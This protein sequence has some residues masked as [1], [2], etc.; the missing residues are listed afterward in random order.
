MNHTC[1]RCGYATRWR[2]MMMLHV[3]NKYDVVLHN[4]EYYSHKHT[5]DDDVINGEDGAAKQA[6]DLV[7]QIT[8]LKKSERCWIDNAKA[9]QVGYNEL[10]KRLHEERTRLDFI[11]SATAFLVQHEGG[12]QVWTA[13]E[14]EIFYVLHDVTLF[15]ATEREAIDEAIARPMKMEVI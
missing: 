1:E 9:L 14:D 12:L 3:C 4:V 8:Q 2:V 11:L 15:F 5:V 13:D 10:N 6:C 7:G